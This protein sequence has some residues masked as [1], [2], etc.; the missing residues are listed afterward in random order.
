M[1]T[2]LELKEYAD[3]TVKM[4]GS[5]IK[6]LLK[7]W[8]YQGGTPQP[9]EKWLHR[10][11]I[12]S[13]LPCP[14]PPRKCPDFGCLPQGVYSLPHLTRKVFFLPHPP[15]RP[16]EIKG[17]PVH[18]WKIPSKM[19]VVLRYTL[20]TLLT[21]WTLFVTVYT[22]TVLFKKSCTYACIY[23]KGRLRCFLWADAFLS[24]MWGDYMEWV[25]WIGGYPFDC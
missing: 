2:K 14:A 16:K 21:L 24:K 7:K 15:S 9:Q 3:T 25:D 12:F 18:P 23:C 4:Y 20:L 13:R 11:R 17:C 10:P 8:K 6:Q 19:E 1:P 5:I 22:I